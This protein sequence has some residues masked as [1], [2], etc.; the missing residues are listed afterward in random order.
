MV[1]NTCSI[2]IYIPNLLINLINILGE[3]Y[4]N[5]ILECC[6]IMSALSVNLKLMSF[7]NKHIKLCLNHSWRTKFIS[8]FTEMQHAYRAA[9]L[10]NIFSVFER[11]IVQS[12]LH[13]S[14]TGSEMGRLA[15]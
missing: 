14:P 15:V 3:Y 8:F 11:L 9:I 7:I 10:F 6:L 1:A 12:V 2:F 5:Y 4:M 13:G